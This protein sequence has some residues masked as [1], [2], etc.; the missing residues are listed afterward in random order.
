M[1][2]PDA[3]ELGEA[4]AR[5][6]P[7]VL[8]SARSLAAW[9]VIGLTAAAALACGAAH[10]PRKPIGLL[11]VGYAVLAAW[12]L[13]WLA[14]KAGVS[15]H[16]TVLAGT[17]LLVAAG[18]LLV[19]LESHRTFAAAERQFWRADPRGWM[20]EQLRQQPDA[21]AADLAPLEEAVAERRQMLDRRTSFA[22]YLRH[23]LTRFVTFPIDSPWPRLIW[24]AEVL[25]GTA[26]GTWLGRRL[27]LA[28][29]TAPDTLEMGGS[30]RQTP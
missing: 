26:L 13:L 9:F 25:A 12:F 14:G 5:L 21:T 20:L 27:A 28:T 23:R 15:S 1:A 2:D 19:G 6:K 16:R 30:E 4:A 24:A 8:S 11:A 17:I 10:L 29:G 18:Q 22:A 3:P 7:P